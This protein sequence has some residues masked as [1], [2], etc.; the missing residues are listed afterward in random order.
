MK[1]QDY[2]RTPTWL[3]SI[4]MLGCAFMLLSLLTA[5]SSAPV[6][7]EVKVPV[8][9]ECRESVPERPAMPTEGFTSK[10]TIDQFAVAAWAEIEIREGYETRLR[11]VAETC[12]KPIR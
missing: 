3:F 6:L 9:V 11:Q 12:T 2:P 10:P 7:T 1:D 4:V 5:C 8:P